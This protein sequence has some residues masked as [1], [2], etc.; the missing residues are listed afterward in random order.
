MLRA[1]NR[2]LARLTKKASADP[3]PVDSPATSVRAKAR[4]TLFVPMLFPS[5][6]RSGEMRVRANL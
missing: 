5:P 6:V 3:T 2:L 4:R 1:R